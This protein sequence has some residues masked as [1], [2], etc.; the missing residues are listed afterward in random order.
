MHRLARSAPGVIGSVAT[1][2][3]VI[4]I[5]LVWLVA[6][7]FFGFASLWLELPAAV[8]SMLAVVLVVLL[9]YSENRDFRALQLKL[10]EVIRAVGEARSELVQLERR[11]DEELAEVEEEFER[12][13]E[14]ESPRGG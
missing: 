1:V 11:S 2:S 10:D 5:V 12:I 7:P 3:A 4:G 6:V 9:Q 14:R 8:A 13:R